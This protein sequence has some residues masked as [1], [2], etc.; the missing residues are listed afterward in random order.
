ME[1]VDLARAVWKPLPRIPTG[2]KFPG[3][4]NR[5]RALGHWQ[6]SVEDCAANFQMRIER[7]TG[8]EKPHDLARSFED[9]V[10]SAIAQESFHRDRR[11][12]AA[13]GRGRCFGTARGA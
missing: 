7:F 11:L 4:E 12:A 13:G 1:I 3:G 2:V 5:S 9:C 10:H 8:N 6:L